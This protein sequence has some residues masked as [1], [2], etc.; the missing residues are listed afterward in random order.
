[1]ETKVCILCGL[2][3]PLEEFT[4]CK[5][6]TDGRGSYCKVCHKAYTK[7]WQ[8]DNPEKV[9]ASKKQSRERNREKTRVKRR[10]D[11][12]EK[13]EVFLQYSRDFAENNPE[14]LALYEA[15]K[16]AKKFNLPCTITEDDIMIPEFCPIL[17]IR[18]VRGSTDDNRDACPSLDR[19]LPDLGYVL[20]NIAVISYRANRLKNDGTI[21]EHRKV[22]DWIE[23]RL[24]ANI[25]VTA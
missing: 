5:K 6:S 20:G 18:L 23:Q 4:K 14:K 3:K 22:A 24:T 9:E 1:M 2:E 19:I 16:R 25:E 8:L 7:Q 13:P 11:R 15:R 12:A 21:E 17:G 10:K